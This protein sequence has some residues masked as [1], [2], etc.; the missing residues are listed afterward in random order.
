MQLRELR[1]NEQS[2]SLT[3]SFRV[4]ACHTPT[5][6]TAM[7]LATRRCIRRVAT[8]PAT[9]SLGHRVSPSQL[10]PTVAPMTAV[11]PATSPLVL[12]GGWGS[13]NTTTVGYA[14]R[15]F[16]TA[17]TAP[18][19]SSVVEITME[20]FTQEVLQSPVPVI[21]D[22]YADWCGPCKQLEPILLKA[23]AASNGKIRLA[24]LDTDKQPQLAQQMQ[25][26]SLPTVFGVHNVSQVVH[27]NRR[28]ACAVCFL[29][30]RDLLTY[31]A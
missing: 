7:F 20:N 18:P 21:L 28:A 16:S 11:S 22:C 17:A 23:V 19:Q 9:A 26:R 29:S 15:T 8:L 24:K 25:V 30:V 6:T 3:T 1:V 2:L 27:N 4:G 31:H 10:L 13:A 12:V 14:N 5:T